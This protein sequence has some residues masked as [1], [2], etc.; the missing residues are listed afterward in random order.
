ME[1]LLMFN[2]LIMNIA[3]HWISLRIIVIN[4]EGLK[5]EL[6][7]FIKEVVKESTK[8]DTK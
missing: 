1:D 6:I 7:I 5:V 2:K 8:V 3:T 4:K